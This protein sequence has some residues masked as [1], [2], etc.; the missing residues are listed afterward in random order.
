MGACTTPQLS[1]SHVCVGMP[2]SPQWPIHRT[3]GARVGNA[4]CGVPLRD[5]VML[6]VTAPHPTI[7]QYKGEQQGLGWDTSCSYALL[8]RLLTTQT[9]GAHNLVSH[10][11]EPSTQR[12]ECSS[13]V[14]TLLKASPW[15]SSHLR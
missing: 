15:L 2:T 7:Y 11:A 4:I 14:K 13:S 10:T 12:W 8:V 3:L 9:Q 6:Q 5:I 1:A